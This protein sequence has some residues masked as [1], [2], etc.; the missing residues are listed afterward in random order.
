VTQNKQQTNTV[1]TAWIGLPFA[2]QRSSS[3]LNFGFVFGKQGNGESNSV[4]ERYMGI[5]FGVIIS[6]GLNDRWFRKFK[7]D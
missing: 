5:N 1:F 7:I 4:N 2:T 3:S 6:P